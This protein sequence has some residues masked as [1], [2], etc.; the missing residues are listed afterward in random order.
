MAEIEKW[1]PM[2]PAG[3]MLSKEVAVV[4]EESV[5]QDMLPKDMVLVL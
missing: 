5:T 1:K 3:G 4:K 2:Y